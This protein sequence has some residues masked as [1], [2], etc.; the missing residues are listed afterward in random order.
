VETVLPETDDDAVRIL[1]IHGAKGLEFPIA[2]VS[3]MTTR[4]QTRRAGVQLRFPH[5][6]DTYALRISARVTTEEFERY[7]PIDE[8][9]DF[10]EKLRLL[11]VAMTRARDHLVVS[12]HRSAREPSGERPTWT[13]AQLVWAAA[14]SQGGWVELGP[15]AS[16]RAV[17]PQTTTTEPPGA[18]LGWA[19]WLAA[20]D[21][22]LAHG[23]RRRVRAATTIAREAA[24]RT[25]AAPDP[26]LRKDARDLDLPPW[27][28]GRYGTA[29]GRAVHAVLQTVDLA[30][31]AGIDDTAA[32]QAAAEGIIGREHEIGSYARAA[33]STPT[34]REAVARC[35]FLFLAADRAEERVVS[36]LPRAI[37]EVR[38]LLAASS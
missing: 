37:A 19:E 1:T 6:R 22:A 35:V 17:M 33:L 13:H 23:S 20:R 16:P 29:I 38:A 21:E 30:T 28:K 26:G 14:A 3:G 18:V 24:T 27:N 31:G 12:V 36:D 7:E 2:I 9:M 32:A 10:H 15:P 25:A 8:Q 34:V 4:A 11:Y 5:D